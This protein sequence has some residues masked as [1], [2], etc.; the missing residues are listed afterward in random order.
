MRSSP[1]PSC[2]GGDCGHRV[3]LSESQARPIEMRSE[4]G[5]ESCSEEDRKLTKTGAQGRPKPCPRVQSLPPDGT[6]NASHGTGHRAA[7]RSRGGRPVLVPGGPARVRAAAPRRAPR[8]LARAA[9]RRRA[10]RVPRLAPVLRPGEPLLRAPPRARCG[11]TRAG[12]LRGADPLDRVHRSAAAHADAQAGGL[13]LPPPRGGAHARLDRVPRRRAGAG[14]RNRARI[15]LHRPLRESAAG[16][17]HLRP[18]R[19]SARESR[20]PHSLVGG[21][22]HPRLQRDAQPGP[23]RTRRAQPCGSSPSSCAA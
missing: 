18:L 16:A 23:P 19:R 10:R 7:R 6:R 2:P 3:R 11:G 12:D 4:R 21:H 1:A 14:A 5:G 9:L 8:R 20:R 17:R 22:P 13:R 15:R